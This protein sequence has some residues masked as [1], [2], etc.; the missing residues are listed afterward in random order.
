MLET[1]NQAIKIGPQKDVG[2]TAFHAASYGGVKF[3]W[4]M[5]KKLVLSVALLILLIPVLWF[6]TFGYGKLRDGS[7]EEAISQYISEI[8]SYKLIHEIYPEKLGA[9]NSAVTNRVL[10]VLPSNEI[11]YRFIDGEYII[12]YVQFPLGPGYVYSS[13]DKDWAYDEI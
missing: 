5:I 2:R 13:K 12:Y 10:G 7:S 4:R 11:K 6:G 8:E 3:M 9:L 1:H